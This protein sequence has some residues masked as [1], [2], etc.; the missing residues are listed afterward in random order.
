[1]KG[2][3]IIISFVPVIHRGYLDFLSKSGAKS[4]CVIEAED[5]S[6]LPHLARELR[7]LQFEEV[8]KILSVF[9]LRALCFSKAV[10]MIKDSDVTLVMPD[11]DVSHF[12]YKKH[13][14]GRKVEYIPTFLRWDWDKS[15]DAVGTTLPNADKVIRKGDREYGDVLPRMNLLLEAREKSSDWW[16][17]IAAMAVCEDG[18]TVVAH[19]THYPNSLLFGLVYHYNL[20]QFQVLPHHITLTFHILHV[21]SLQFFQVC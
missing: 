4:V 2:G 17:Q 9:G 19:N 21:E 8:Q 7:A 16:R 10:S 14:Q 12:L 15:I 3:K 13:F 1:M 20:H 18:T 11:E 6:E 5:V